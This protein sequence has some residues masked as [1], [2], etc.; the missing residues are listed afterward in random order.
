MKVTKT[1]F[2]RAMAFFCAIAC[3]VCSVVLAIVDNELIGILVPCLFQC[4][5]IVTLLI[6]PGRSKRRAHARRPIT[7][8]DADMN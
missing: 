7:W 5:I 1:Q 3:A 6:V 2:F 8:T 4:I